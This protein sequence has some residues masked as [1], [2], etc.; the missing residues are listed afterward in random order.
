MSPE[1]AATSP[2]S[3]WMRSAYGFV[4]WARRWAAANFVFAIICIVL[5]IRWMLDTATMRFLISRIL[6]H[7]GE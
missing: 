7:G 3:L 1:A 4:A 5:V 2:T 6:R